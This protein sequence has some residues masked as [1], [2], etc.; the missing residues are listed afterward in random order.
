MLETM[1][2]CQTGKNRIRGKLAETILVGHKTCSSG[3]DKKGISIATNDI[4]IITLSNGQHFGI[5]VLVDNSCENEE[6]N[7]LIIAEVSKIAF[8]FFNH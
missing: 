4:G 1:L 7:A 6:T 5:T 2:K 8:D 3:A